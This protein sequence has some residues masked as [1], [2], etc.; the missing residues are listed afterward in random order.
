MAEEYVPQDEQDDW[1]EGVLVPRRRPFK[2]WYLSFVA[3][4]GLW[5][6]SMAITIPFLVRSG[7]DLFGQRAP[8]PGQAT[9]QLE[10]GEYEINYDEISTIDG[11]I[12]QSPAFRSRD[13]LAIRMVQ[14]DSEKEL[15]L[16][17]KYD[18]NTYSRDRRTRSGQTRYAGITLY[19]LTVSEPGEY[20]LHGTP[21]PGEESYVLAVEANFGRSVGLGLLLGL[22]TLIGWLSLIGLL[23][24]ALI[25][26]ISG[27]VSRKRRDINERI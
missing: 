10:A 15:A 25:H 17:P 9:F 19:T 13:D 11:R 3:G 22:A 21:L 8:M 6:V 12:V 18:R 14:A 23:V 20:V 7:G 1:A 24:T 16:T 26:A 2:P 27:T 5:I 4:V